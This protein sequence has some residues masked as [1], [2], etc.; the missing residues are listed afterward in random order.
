MP[1]LLSLPFVV[2]LAA[3][4]GSGGRPMPPESWWNGLDVTTTPQPASGVRA[5][6]LP[7]PERVRIPGGRFRMG[8]T[9][10]DLSTAILL[11]QL[12]PIA[13]EKL[14]RSPELE[15]E[16]KAESPSHLVTLSA[17]EID[18]TEVSVA[19]YARCV[20]A[21]ACAEPGF[22][23][24][25]PQFDRPQLPVTHVSWD[26]AATYCAWAGGRL[27]TEAEWEMAA[28]GLK[29]REF[30]WGDVY[31]PHLCNHGARFG[32]HTTVPNETDATDG[33]TGL[34]PVD[35]LTD[36]AT[37]EGVLNMAGNASEWVADFYQ[38]DE[39]G[40][41]YTTQP[42]NNPKGPATNSGLGHVVRGGSYLDGAAWMRGAWRTFAVLQ[43][44]REVGFRC[45]RDAR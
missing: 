10:G 38:I 40:F 11:C 37:P 21:G 44:P 32:P 2:V 43:R 24:G 8:S 26:D 14:C 34:A 28:R 18:R 5:M 31:N 1:P 17:F 39:N 29:S 25:D 45:A 3:A 19:S 20:A 12:E 36:G 4:G 23:A 33:Y 15:R 13:A 30:P 41:G 42:Q 35:A 7:P 27:P 9:P 16:L 22:T 6:Q